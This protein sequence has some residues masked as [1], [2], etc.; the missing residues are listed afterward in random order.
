MLTTSSIEQLAVE[1]ASNVAVPSGLASPL[2]LV[3]RLQTPVPPPLSQVEFTPL[4][5]VEYAPH[6]RLA[7]KRASPPTSTTISDRF[8]I[9]PS[10]VGLAIIPPASGARTST[11]NPCP[12]A[13]RYWM[14]SRHRG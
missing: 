13:R 3:A 10:S 12:K 8:L 5:S 1:V 6:P 7:R 14:R 11:N 4:S 9:R 2:Q